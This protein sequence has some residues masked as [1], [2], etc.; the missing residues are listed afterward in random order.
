MQKE[1]IIM[2]TINQTLVK[3][4][5]IIKSFNSNK[6]Q[7]GFQRCGLKGNTIFNKNVNKTQYIKLIKIFIN[8][9]SCMNKI[10]SAIKLY[11]NSIHLGFSKKLKRLIF[12][13]S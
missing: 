7:A 3:L 13:R 12:R 4:E 9:T 5:I 10:S 6:V 2:I 11:P 1:L 8:K